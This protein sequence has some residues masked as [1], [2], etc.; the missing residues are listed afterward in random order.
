MQFRNSED[1]L[2]NVRVTEMSS[3]KPVFNVA[4][5]AGPAPVVRSVEVKGTRT[6]LGLIQ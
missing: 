5:Y 6:D 1:V 2:H 3:Q 4:I